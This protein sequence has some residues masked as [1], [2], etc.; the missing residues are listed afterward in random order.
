M[1][2]DQYLKNNTPVVILFTYR[3]H[4]KIGL[5]VRDLSQRCRGIREREIE[6]ATMLFWDRSSVLL[7]RL[8]CHIE[9]SFPA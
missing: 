7:S 8:A 2:L 1:R 3:S 6:P 9:V 4:A 5:D